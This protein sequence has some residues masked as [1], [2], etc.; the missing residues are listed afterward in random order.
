MDPVTD[1]SLFKWFIEWIIYSHI[2]LHWYCCMILQN[3][4]YCHCFV[5]HC[6][7]FVCFFLSPRKLLKFWSSPCSGPGLIQLINFNFLAQHHIQMLSFQESETCQLGNFTNSN[8]MAELHNKIF[9]NF[10]T[11]SCQKMYCIMWNWITSL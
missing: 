2:G 4:F 3:I 10:I 6:F 7:F 5:V 11:N 8:Y 9:S 1:S